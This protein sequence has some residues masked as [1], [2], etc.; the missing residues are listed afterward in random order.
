VV[1]SFSST[2]Q[3]RGW[4]TDP[5]VDRSAYHGPVASLNYRPRAAR[6]GR[7][8]VL[9]GSQVLVPNMRMQLTAGHG[10]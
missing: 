3:T 7:R 8:M 6:S 5:V 10:R 2:P 9:G 1:R 4:S